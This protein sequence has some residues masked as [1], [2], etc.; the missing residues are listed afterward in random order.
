MRKLVEVLARFS[1]CIRI[2]FLKYLLTHDINI[3][4]VREFIVKIKV[5][6]DVTGEG[7]GSY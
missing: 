4:D 1:G 7:E 6:V 3:L 5:D 2:G